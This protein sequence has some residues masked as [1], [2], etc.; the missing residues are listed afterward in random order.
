MTALGEVLPCCIV[1][2]FGDYNAII[3]EMT[4]GNAAKTSMAE[5]WNGPRAVA[6]RRSLASDTPHPYCA[7]CSKYWNVL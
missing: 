6:F 1:P 4:L 2:Q 7:R 3:E 5:V